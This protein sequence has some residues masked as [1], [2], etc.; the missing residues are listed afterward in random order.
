MSSLMAFAFKVEKDKE[1][2]LL[3][4]QIQ[5]HKNIWVITFHLH[6]R[7]LADV[8]PNLQ[9]LNKLKVLVHQICKQP[10]N[11]EGKGKTEGKKSNVPEII[12]YY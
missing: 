5:I 8:L 7:H 12:M 1:S 10:N 9:M 2:T 3:R 11:K 6:F 4:K